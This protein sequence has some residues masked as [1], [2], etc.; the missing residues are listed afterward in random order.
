MECLGQQTTESNA[1]DQTEYCEFIFR[2]FDEEF[3][4]LNCLLQTSKKL[5]ILSMCPHLLP[6]FAACEYFY[7]AK[8]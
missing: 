7:I 6:V 4:I 8:K 1:K 2:L 5:R 3:E